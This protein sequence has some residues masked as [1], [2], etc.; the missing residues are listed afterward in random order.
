MPTGFTAMIEERDDV[1]FEEFCWACARGM[2]ACVMMR[3]SRFDAPVTD[4]DVQDNS[5]YYADELAKNKKKL[6]AL[7]EMHPA[8][9]QILAKEEF[10][11]AMVNRLDAIKKD[12]EQA[13]RYDKIR[14]K[15]EAWVPPTPD[16]VGLKEFMLQQIQVSTEY[17]YDRPAPVLKSADAWMAQ[18]FE[19][20]TRRIVRGNE[21]LAGQNGRNAERV[22]W[23]RALRESV[24]QPK[25]KR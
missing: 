17:R 21:D 6:A 9:V 2:G 8:Q 13:A 11:Q 4:E 24:P 22:A 3:E 1:T 20:L 23:I 18:E 5:T 19:I 12:A 16:H 15:V 25:A 7:A 14:R 10:E